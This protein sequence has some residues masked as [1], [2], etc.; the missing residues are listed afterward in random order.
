MK[1]EQDKNIK[2]SEKSS[3][4]LENYKKFFRYLLSDVDNELVEEVD[5]TDQIKPQRP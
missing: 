1:Q 4:Q 5:K 3:E 2:N